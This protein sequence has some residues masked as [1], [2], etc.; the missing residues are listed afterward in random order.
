MCFWITLSKKELPA[1]LACGQRWT[2]PRAVP[3]LG[4]GSPPC[5]GRSS[6]SFHPKRPLECSLRF[7]HHPQRLDTGLVK[8]VSWAK[9]EVVQLLICLCSYSL[10]CLQSVIL[11]TKWETVVWL[12]D[13]DK[14]K[15]KAWKESRVT[16]QRQHPRA[17]ANLGAVFTSGNCLVLTSPWEIGHPIL[18]TGKQR[19]REAEELAR[20]HMGAH[21]GT[22]IWIQ[23]GLLWSFYSV[24]PPSMT[25]Y[26]F[27][28]FHFEIN[29]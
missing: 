13:G 27:L 20:C 9:V 21:L 11:K 12:S 1:L 10:I 2:L 7:P 8:R 24:S 19:F 16:H 25:V 28:I 22:S 17:S 5:P 6:F 15:K 29:Q 14:D 4:S 23:I 3:L 26:L 18:L